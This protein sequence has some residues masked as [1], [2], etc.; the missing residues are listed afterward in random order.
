[1]GSGVPPPSQHALR[2]TLAP[3]PKALPNFGRH[4]RSTYM[5]IAWCLPCCHLLPIACCRYDPNKVFESILMSRF[6]AKQ[7]NLYSPQCDLKRS[8]YCTQD[9]HCAQGFA[10][11]PLASF[12]QF[13]VCKPSPMLPKLL[14]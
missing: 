9:S 1:M 6:I 2:M 5:C 14:G 10:C 13:K 3:I 4:W 12:P 7:P 8:C 11:V